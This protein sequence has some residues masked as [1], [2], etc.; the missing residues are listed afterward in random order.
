MRNR[1]GK[2]Y[3]LRHL[4]YLGNHINGIKHGKG[5]G[6]YNKNSIIFEGEY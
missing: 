4:K 5:T 6:Y 2:E 1:K 3:Y